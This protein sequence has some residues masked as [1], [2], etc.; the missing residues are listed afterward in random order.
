MCEPA[1]MAARLRRTQ[2]P[3]ETCQ[4]SCLAPKIWAVLIPWWSPLPGRGRGLRAAG[5]WHWVL[6]VL[7]P[8]S[9]CWLGHALV[10]AEATDTGVPLVIWV[11]HWS[12]PCRVTRWHT[13]RPKRVCYCRVSLRS[14]LVTALEDI[15][16]VWSLFAGQVSILIHFVA[17]YLHSEE[18]FVKKGRCVGEFGTCKVN[19]AAWVE[20]SFCLPVLA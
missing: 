12:Q 17:I 4:P 14:R 13:S 9:D 1:D 16:P 19:M 3:R 6:Y 7:L 8:L 20:G 5:S 2:K 18:T 10:M 11:S 15:L